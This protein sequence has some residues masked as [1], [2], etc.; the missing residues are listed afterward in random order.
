MVACLA[1]DSQKMK[2]AG[3]SLLDPQ[4]SC[5]GS[6]VIH[7]AAATSLRSLRGPEIWERARPF[8]LVGNICPRLAAALEENGAP[9]GAVAEQL[10]FEILLMQL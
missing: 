7:T 6:S 5:E 9:E 2:R 3:G 1:I 8:L 10:L 4:D